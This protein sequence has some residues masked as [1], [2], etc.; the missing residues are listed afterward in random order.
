MSEKIILGS[1]KLYLAEFTGSIPD[2]SAIETE[3]NRIGHIQGGASIEYKPTFYEAKDDL[4]LV[5]KKI[6]TDEEAVLKSGIMTWDLDKL[7]LLCNTGTVSEDP[8]KNIRTLKIGGLG[9][10]DDKQYVIHFLH[11]DAQDGDMRVTIVGQNEAGFTV[12]WAKDKET[13]I[14]AEFKAQPN[15]TEGTLI[16]LQEDIVAAVPAAETHLAALT[17]GLAPLTPAFNPGTYN[18]TAT[19]DD[20]APIT[21][22]AKDSEATIEIKLNDVTHTNGEEATWAE[23]NTVTITVSKGTHSRVYTI[24]AT[25]TSE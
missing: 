23:T 3:A 13:V 15:D 11:E 5:S 25:K 8:V 16:L 24:I 18:Y 1:G 4:G 7:A 6:I 2:N 20:D 10:Y 21:A 14:N 12:A 17:L 9:N 22:I 19:V